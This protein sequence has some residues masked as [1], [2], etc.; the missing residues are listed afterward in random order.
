MVEVPRVQGSTILFRRSS[1]TMTMIRSIVGLAF[2]VQR[3]TAPNYWQDATLREALYNRVTYIPG[4]SGNQMNQNLWLANFWNN[5]DNAESQVCGYRAVDG[6][7]VRMLFCGGDEFRDGKL[8]RSEKNMNQCFARIR[9][10][11]YLKYTYYPGTVELKDGKVRV[12]QQVSAKGRK[13]PKADAQ[14][15]I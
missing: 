4:S 5:W 3:W 7:P 8:E 12:T 9:R 15:V 14:I 11:S 10:E 13:Q 2:N 6:A 1:F